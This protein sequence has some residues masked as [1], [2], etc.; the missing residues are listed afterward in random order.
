MALCGGAGVSGSERAD[1]R[2]ARTIVE[3]YIAAQNRHDLAAVMAH[4]ATDAVFLL[5]SGRPPVTGKP[6]IE[7]LERF[8]IYAASTLQPFGLTFARD[9]DGWTVSIA[10][11]IE[12]S[13]VFSAMGMVIVR[14][15]P[16]RD[17]FVIRPDQEPKQH[18]TAPFRSRFFLS[19]SIT[20]MAGGTGG[21]RTVGM[22]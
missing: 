18:G 15:Q 3:S 4:Y 1:E 14:T 6:A 13:A 21:I 10:G 22:V 17:G 20:Y 12:N 7:R 8:D 19:I 16:V 9:G 5:N 2:D 11:V